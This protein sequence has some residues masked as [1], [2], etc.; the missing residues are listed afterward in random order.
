[1][2]QASKIILS[3]VFA[4][5]GATYA[6]CPNNVQPIKKGEVAVCD[7]FL[8]SDG[9]EKTASQARDDADY[10]KKLSDK[11]QEKSDLEDKQSQILNDRLKLYIDESKALSKT[12]AQKDN[13][14]SLYRFVYFALGVVITGVIAVNVRR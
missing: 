9:A 1:M 2:E 13:T 3:V 14:E 5:S 11:L 8:F 12:V 7:G 4:F 10:Y 6:D